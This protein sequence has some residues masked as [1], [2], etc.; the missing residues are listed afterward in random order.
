MKVTIL[1][2]SGFIG[3]NLM[4]SLIDQSIECFAPQREYV[5][6]KKE[7]LGHVI[8]CIGLTSDFRARPMDTVQ[9]HVCKL[10]EVLQNSNF[11]SFLYLSSTRIYNGNR[12]G[13]E[14][15]DVKVNSSNFS[16]LYNISKLMGES[17]CLSIANEN[18]RIARLSNVIGNDFKS[19]NYLFSL[20]KEAVN[21]HQIHLQ[22]PLKSAKDYVSINDVVKN[23]ILISQN[24]KQRIYN[25][26]SG[27]QISNEQIVNSIKEETNCKVEVLANSDGLIFPQI[28]IERIVNE[29]NFT[30]VNIL[31]D[32]SDLIKNYK[33]NNYDTN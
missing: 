24:G 32:I 22:L 9:A 29:F 31:N 28:S 2:S 1:G 27:F 6:S 5:F 25:I 20:I 30:P 10:I 33:E 16:D 26:A 19:D 8:Y 14:T 13:R 7:N 15:D 12:T 23:A 21:T 11:E 18:I 3:L 4:N 17:I